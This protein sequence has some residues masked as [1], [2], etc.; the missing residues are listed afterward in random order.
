[1]KKTSII[2]ILLLICALFLSGCNI[3][4]DLLFFGSR[5]TQ[6]SVSLSEDTMIID[7]HAEDK[8]NYMSENARIEVRYGGEIGVTGDP[9]WYCETKVSYGTTYYKCRNSDLVCE[10][11]WRTGCQVNYATYLFNE[12]P[13]I[14]EAESYIQVVGGNKTFI[15]DGEPSL[16]NGFNIGPC[17]S[18]FNENEEVLNGR[19]CTVFAHYV[20]HKQPGTNTITGDVIAEQESGV[21]VQLI[22]QPSPWSRFWAW[23]LSLF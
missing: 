17:L 15:C 16:N 1:M 20:A 5:V 2:M 4:G 11:V 8:C 23:L 10:G 6:P 19:S 7:V 21:P 12:Y 22:D 14:N 13:Y 9:D 18:V 3:S